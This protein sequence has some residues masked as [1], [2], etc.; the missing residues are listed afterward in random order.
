MMAGF[1]RAGVQNG[2]G[3]QELYPLD[4]MPS[5]ITQPAASP[6]ALGR[7][8]PAPARTWGRGGGGKVGPTS[9]RGRVQDA[10]KGVWDGDLGAV[11]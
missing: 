8:V 2:G 1:P 11:I 10:L 4:P 7:A 9:Q 6:P 5:R 3:R